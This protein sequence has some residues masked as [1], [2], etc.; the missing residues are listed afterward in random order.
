MEAGKWIKT[1]YVVGG[2]HGIEWV[3]A[4]CGLFGG[5]ERGTV[6]AD[7]GAGRHVIFRWTNPD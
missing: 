3:T 2:G 1:P 5:L 4:G 6:E 7:F